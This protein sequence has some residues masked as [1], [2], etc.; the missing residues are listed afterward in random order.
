MAMTLVE[1]ILAD[2]AGLARVK[3]GEFVVV[4]VDL[5]AAHDAA[6][7]LVLD[8]FEATGAKCVF[9]RDRVAMIMRAYV[10]ARDANV[11]QVHQ[12]MREFARD[13]Q[14]THFYDYDGGDCGIEHAVYPQAGLVYPGAV[15]V[16]SDSHTPTS[17]AF[18]AFAPAMGWSDAAAAFALGTAWF[19]VPA[20]IRLDI[21]GALPAYVTAKDVT[22]DVMR[23]LGPD[24]AAY[25][26]LEYSG[27]T[28]SSM[29]M[30]E[31]MTLCNMAVECGAKT[32]VVPP[33]A[34]TRAWL[35][36]KVS[37]AYTE[38]VSDPG[39]V[40]ERTI[41]I[42]AEG[43][44]VTVAR[45]ES[46]NNGVPIS[47]VAG[48]RITQVWIGSCTNGRITDLRAAAAVLRG[49]RVAKGVRLVV[50]PASR[51]D[52]LLAVK[53]GL[54][55]VFMEAGALVTAASCGPCA[56]LHSGVLGSSDV[57]VS[58]SNRNFRGRM[59]HPNSRVYLASPIVAAASAVTGAITHPGQILGPEQRQVD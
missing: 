35:A 41:R 50:S 1:K 44:D 49:R 15:I 33:D 47:E 18:G 45:P 39:A 21:N 5:A 32:A 14:L 11:A 3:P 40:Y 51:G 29:S 6:A 57:C 9:D 31:R 59:G 28:I 56:G 7:T 48:T 58:T 17:G 36:G 8:T 12:R 25:R 42:A 24:G 23:R 46:P 2:K 13:Q 38:Y 26:A 53:E 27:S 43:L 34:M 54:V 52:F 22:L 30:E 19:R 10:P 55:E 37:H 20:T 16:N 4:P